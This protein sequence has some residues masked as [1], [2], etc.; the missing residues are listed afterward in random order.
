MGQFG[1]HRPPQDIAFAPDRSIAQAVS[2]SLASSSAAMVVGED[3]SPR[4]SLY[5]EFQNHVT[6]QSSATGAGGASI[7]LVCSGTWRNTNKRD[8]PH[9]GRAMGPMLGVPCPVP[10]APCWACHGLAVKLSLTPHLHVAATLPI[11]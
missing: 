2:V 8:M 7:V 11:V 4:M 1:S 5:D 9:A 10:W 3:V 6:V